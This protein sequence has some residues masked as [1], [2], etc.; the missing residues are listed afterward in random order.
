MPTARYA[1]PSMPTPDTD[2]YA[3]YPNL[4]VYAVPAGRRQGPGASGPYAWEQLATL[5]ALSAGLAHLAGAGASTG[6]LEQVE[7][8]WHAEWMALD[9]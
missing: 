7:A 2:Y 1:I 5:L 6:M 9:K 3:D 8:L 4:G